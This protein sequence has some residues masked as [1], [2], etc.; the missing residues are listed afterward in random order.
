MENEHKTSLA[1]CRLNSEQMRR[2]DSKAKEKGIPRSMLIKHIILEY[3]D[4]DIT[5]TNI[6]QASM[7]KIIEKMNNVS[8]K[9][10]FFQQ[11]FYS[12]L[13]NW[14]ASHP[15]IND[16]SES[17]LNSSIE[18]R[19]NFAKNFINDIYNNSDQLYETLFA[20]SVEDQED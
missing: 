17:L 2:L 20:N 3:L 15:Q 11:M 9:Q 12:F 7:Q 8:E 1:S 14:F 13:V 4:K 5:H 18:R 10:E 16:D 19:D 6:L